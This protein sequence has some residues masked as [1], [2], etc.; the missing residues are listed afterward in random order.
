MGAIGGRKL[1]WYWR[2]RG[3]GRWGGGA[4]MN[5]RL[6]NA[7]WDLKK[8]KK[9]KKK[10][11]SRCIDSL[12]LSGWV[13][14]GQRNCYSHFGYDSSQRVRACFAC[15]LINVEWDLFSFFFCKFNVERFVSGSHII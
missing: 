4:K 14:P 8:K 10:N 13:F 7:G 3:R 11:V 5:V 12:S 15:D 6:S 2:E 1:N 9:K